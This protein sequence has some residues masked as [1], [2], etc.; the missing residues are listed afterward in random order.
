MPIQDKNFYNQASATKL[1]WDPSWFNCEHFDDELEKAIE[2]FQKNHG[3]IP[4]GLVGPDTFKKIYAERE[5]HA[6]MIMH[7][8]NQQCNKL[9]NKKFIVCNGNQVEIEWDKVDLNTLKLTS[10]FKSYNGT[11]DVIQ[12]ICHWD[13]ALSSK[14]CHDILIKRGLSVAFTI[15]NDGTI[16]QMVDTNPICW[17]AQGFNDHSVGVEITNAVEMQYQN[18]YITKGFGARPVMPKVNVHNG[19]FPEHLGFYPV[20]IE[21]LKALLKSVCGYYK[22]PFNVPLD[23]QGNVIHGVISDPL[24]F[25]G[26]M[27]H[28]HNTERKTDPISLDFKKLAEDL[29]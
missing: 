26:V 22:I 1:N 25:K 23:N 13:G 18:Y 17:H 4:D 6:A 29:K 24:H 16:Y 9:S 7:H 8:V 3:L 12:F 11:R 19:T 14:S 21:A 15:D 20:Q 2:E 27:G 28:Y 10:G 5:A